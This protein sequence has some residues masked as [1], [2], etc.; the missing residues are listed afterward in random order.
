MNKN[1]IL[2]SVAVLLTASLACGALDEAGTQ[3]AQ[4]ATARSQSAP[5]ATETQSLP[6]TGATPTEAPAATDTAEPRQAAGVGDR[7][8]KSGVALTV[9]SIAFV[10]KSSFATA[11]E[12][13]V[14]LVAEVLIENTATD[15]APYNPLYFKV[16]DAEGFE[17]TSTLIAPDP[18]LKSGELAAGEKARGNVAFEVP[19]A[20][21]DL[22]LTYKPLVLWGDV[23]V[24]VRLGDARAP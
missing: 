23:D 24:K 21:K 1:N 18:T 3:V 9:S 12:G 19:V 22:V 8:E 16:K 11:K 14:F 2:L 7:V 15:K 17:Y 4:T 13:N 10:N 6:V 20:A 5:A